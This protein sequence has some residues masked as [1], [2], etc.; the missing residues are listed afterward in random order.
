MKGTKRVK[1]IA[2]ALVL[3]LAVGIFAGWSFSKVKGDIGITATDADNNSVEVTGGTATIAFT[4]AVQQPEQ[5]SGVGDD[6]G[7]DHNGGNK[8]DDIILTFDEYHHSFNFNGQGQ[9]K[10]G[11]KAKIQAAVDAGYTATLTYTLKATGYT[12]VNGRIALADLVDSSNDKNIKFNNLSVEFEKAQ[13][14]LTFS[15][16]KGVDTVTVNGNAV[17]LDENNQISVTYWDV[18]NVTT[19][20]H[21]SVEGN[22]FKNKKVIS[23]V[24]SGAEVNIYPFFDFDINDPVYTNTNKN[25]EEDWYTSATISAGENFDFDKYTVTAKLGENGPE[26][27]IT[28]EDSAEFIASGTVTIT[29]TDIN[30]K[31]QTWT[32]TV[33]LKNVDGTAPVLNGGFEVKSVWVSSSITA[34]YHWSVSIAA[35]KITEDE[36]NIKEIKIYSYY[37]GI[38]RSGLNKGP[39]NGTMTYNEEKNSYEYTSEH[40]FGRYD[41]SKIT[42]TIVDKAG[43][44]TEY[45]P[46]SAYVT[47]APD[48]YNMEDTGFTDN[49]KVT[50]SNVDTKPTVELWNPY[51][52]KKIKDMTVKADGTTY[53]FETTLNGI[54]KING[55]PYYVYRTNTDGTYTGYID[56]EGPMF[57]VDGI[58]DTL[59]SSSVKSFDITVRDY[60]GPDKG[61]DL[62]S[63]VKQFAGSG[64][65]EVKYAQVN[66]TTDGT[67]EEKTTTTDSTTTTVYN[68]KWSYT[69]TDANGNTY[70]A[71]G[72]VTSNGEKSTYSDTTSAVNAA[73]AE[74]ETQLKSWL[75][76]NYADLKNAQTAIANEDGTY[77]IAGSDGAYN[78]VIWATDNLN[79]TTVTITDKAVTIDNSAPAVSNVN[80][81]ELNTGRYNRTGEITI[82]AKVSDAH[83]DKVTAILCDQAGTEVKSVEMTPK[84]GT[85]TATIEVADGDNYYVKV[86]AVDLAENSTTSNATA[87]FTVDTKAPAVSDVNVTELNT[88]RYSSSSEITISA[89]VS[90]N[91]LAT[92]TAN[93]YDQKNNV[94]EEYEKGI[95]LT[96]DDKDGTYTATI[97]VKDGDNYYVKV[98][99]VDL[100]ENSTTSNATAPFTVDTTFPEM[101]DCGF[102]PVN[103]TKDYNFFNKDR[104]LTIIFKEHHY[105]SGCFVYVDSD[106]EEKTEPFAIAENES[107]GNLVDNG[108]DSYKFTKTFYDVTGDAYA[109]L[110]IQLTDKAG[111]V[112]VYVFNGEKTKKDFDKTVVVDYETE[113]A[114][115]TVDT[116]VPQVS[117]EYNKITPSNGKYFNADRYAIITVNEHNFNYE[118]YVKTSS[119]FANIKTEELESGVYIIVSQTNKDDQAKDG[120]YTIAKEWVDVEE[121]ADTHTLKIDYSGNV[122]YTFNVVVVDKAGNISADPN[123]DGN[124]DFAPEANADFDVDKV[125]TAPTITGVSGGSAYNGNVTG[126]VNYSDANFQNA[127]I[128]LTRADRNSVYDV[129]AQHTSALPTGGTGGDVQ[130]V[131]FD[132][133]LSND[134]IYTL[135][136][137]ITDKAGNTAENSVTFSVNRFGS[138]YQ[139]DDY[140]SSICDKH[141]TAVTGD[142]KIT[143]INPDS[144]S[145]GSV[146]ITHNG[147]VIK[148]DV[149]AVLQKSGSASGGWYEYLYTISK[150][151]F[152]EDGLYT[153][154]INSKDAAGNEPSSQNDNTAEIKFWVDDTKSELS[155]ITGL[156]EAII[157]GEKQ[158][159]TFSISD[160]IGLKSVVVYCDGK[161]IATFGENDF[162][163]G[164]LKDAVFTIDEASS[165]QHIRIVAEDQSGNVFDTDEDDTLTFEH[166]VTVSTNFFVRWFANKPLFF[167]SIAAIVII[168]AGIWFAVAK[169]KKNED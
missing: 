152:T 147:K 168:G 108:D 128:R 95:A 97:T 123:Y 28:A 166:D 165:A 55:N 71:N 61:L 110:Y 52:E 134:G 84:D 105:A 82:S 162:T 25:H 127:T 66:W 153:I 51:T 18:I 122:N 57:G 87:P 31:T 46:S 27:Q 93:L 7:N 167:G 16:P 101:T 80:V 12:D 157:N 39:E 106:G 40:G 90:D 142:L 158:D 113:I 132:R 42:V 130:L 104:V 50:I 91:H 34:N 163:A 54:Y 30:D 29:V 38:W 78:Y 89:K 59:P 129:T 88:G 112:K 21:Y 36:D 98:T 118:K 121:N 145:D 15:E 137:T 20:D 44:K 8:P 23:G 43:N 120:N 160:N 86:T 94:V 169:K 107:T 9:G 65:K 154:V 58:I 100:A 72:Y 150:D 149:K 14:T 141:I 2:V 47:F 5:P 117:V 10:D 99:A 11:D 144:L 17:S 161:V 1:L 74:A 125:I 45:T 103:C 3:L 138:T 26:Q 148:N 102:E 73:K 79:H 77:K 85:Y 70:S 139:F 119:Q 75:K 96:D 115:F 116:T 164:N 48:I 111:N 124:K 41:T 83:L 81:T 64:V 131:N 13:Y 49:V 136:A 109:P 135:T 6:E 63:Y 53:T 156:E 126:N 32:K 159:V 133:V 67:S 140:L 56:I 60:C 76:N 37:N 92:V 24:T 19:K 143:E 35:D 33:E 69:I 62:D 146:T 22:E 4:T 68:A 114:P 155:G 151:K